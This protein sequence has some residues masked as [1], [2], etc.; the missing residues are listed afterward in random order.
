MRILK[1]TPRVGFLR[2]KKRK[3]R[4]KFK[5]N[6]KFHFRFDYALIL[7]TITI[8]VIRFVSFIIFKIHNFIFTCNS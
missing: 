6:Y 2:K 5:I 7:F 8:L 3:K 1:T 4:V